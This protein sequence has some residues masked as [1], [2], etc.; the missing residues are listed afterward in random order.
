MKSFFSFENNGL[1]SFELGA[2]RGGTSS[3]E[4]QETTGKKI[5]FI[6]EDILIPD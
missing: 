6:D 1:N 4:T 3:G 5:D 2:I